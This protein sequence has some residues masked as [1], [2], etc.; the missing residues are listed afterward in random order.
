MGP[1][2]LAMLQVEL[3]MI[4]LTTIKERQQLL[5]HVTMVLEDS[6]LDA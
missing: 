2:H 3:P 4:G 6:T 1:R 5:G